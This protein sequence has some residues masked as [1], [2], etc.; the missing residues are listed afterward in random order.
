MGTWDTI[1]VI[2]GSKGSPNRHLEVQ[3]CIFIDFKVIL[4]GSWDQL[5]RNFR[6]F[7]VICGAKL[8]GSSQ[9]LLFEAPGVEMQPECNGCMC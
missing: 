3:V 5:W 7:S 2:L 9:V 8:A 1:L 4:G 6:Y